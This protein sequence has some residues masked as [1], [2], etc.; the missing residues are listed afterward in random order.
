M[1]EVSTPTK[2]SEACM[3]GIRVNGGVSYGPALVKG[4]GSDEPAPNKERTTS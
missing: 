3:T 4:G 1:A 2:P